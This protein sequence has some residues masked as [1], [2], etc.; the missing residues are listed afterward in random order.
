MNLV[1]IEKIINK[2]EGAGTFAVDTPLVF[3]RISNLV[4]SFDWSGAFVRYDKS[5]VV[6]KSNGLYYIIPVLRTDAAPAGGTIGVDYDYV[7]GQYWLYMKPHGNFA[8]DILSISG[9]G[10]IR[11]YEKVTGGII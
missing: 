7:N 3:Y 8:Y 10:A 9:I 2:V 6:F 4:N 11:L 5:R 1:K